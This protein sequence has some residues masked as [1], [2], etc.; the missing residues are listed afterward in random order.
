MRKVVLLLVITAITAVMFV[1]PAYAG[2]DVDAS[3]V[4][5]KWHG[6][7]GPIFCADGSNQLTISATTTSMLMVTATWVYINGITSLGTSRNFTAT[8]VRPFSGVVVMKY[9]NNTY[10]SQPFFVKVGWFPNDMSMPSI[11]SGGAQ[12]PSNPLLPSDSTAAGIISVV[13]SA[14]AA[15]PDPDPIYLGCHTEACSTF[16]GTDDDEC[17]DDTD[18]I[19]KW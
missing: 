5:Y 19:D 14:D 2:I 18:C 10:E 3:G 16:N 1:V 9:S 4:R 6:A 11:P 7:N 13:V 15:G 17:E 8:S 12:P